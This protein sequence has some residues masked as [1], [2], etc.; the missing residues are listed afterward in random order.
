M[1]RSI[2]ALA[3]LA[4]N[5]HLPQNLLALLAH[6]VALA[7]PSNVSLKSSKPIL[8]CPDHKTRIGLSLLMLAMAI[9]N[10]KKT[11]TTMM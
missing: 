10:I 6:A 5:F 8:V 2:I 7:L 4:S 1:Q 11:V 9:M 3:G